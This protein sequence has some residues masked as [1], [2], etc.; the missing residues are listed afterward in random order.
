MTVHAPH[1]PSSHTRLLP[2][3]PSDSRSVSRRVRRGGTHADTAL[4]FTVSAMSIGPGPRS[5]APFTEGTW[6]TKKC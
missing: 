2:V 1:V 3:S 5:A 4:P 6:G